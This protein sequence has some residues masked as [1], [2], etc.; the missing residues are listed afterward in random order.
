M[1]D[2]IVLAAT[3]LPTWG[4]LAAIIL[5]YYLFISAAIALVLAAA[6]MFLLTWLR[7]KVENL[8]KVQP[9]ITRM[10]RALLAGLNN[11]PLPPELADHQLLQVVAQVPR[12]TAMLPAQASAVEQKVEQGSDRVVQAVIEFRARTEMVKGMAKAFFLPGLTRSRVPAQTVGVR[13]PEPVGVP[14]E[15]MVTQQEGIIEPPPYEEVVMVQR[16][17]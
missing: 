5:V 7:E 3:G 6:L 15:A 17:R 1:N 10:N 16:M 11:E 4:Q 14:P 9:A 12:V 13:E 8:K 2:V